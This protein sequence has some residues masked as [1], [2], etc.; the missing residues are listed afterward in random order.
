MANGDAEVLGQ[1]SYVEQRPMSS[2]VGRCS[3][4]SHRTPPNARR[5]VSNRLLG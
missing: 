3:L 4:Q 5:V 2:R 1:A